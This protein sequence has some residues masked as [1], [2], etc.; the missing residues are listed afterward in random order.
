[1]PPKEE[2][3]RKERAF[4][5]CYDLH[6][7]VLFS[8]LPGSVIVYTV[9]LNEMILAILLIVGLLLLAVTVTISPDLNSPRWRRR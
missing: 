2:M 7:W 1:M 5:F 9:G 3:T 8:M 4:V 6:G